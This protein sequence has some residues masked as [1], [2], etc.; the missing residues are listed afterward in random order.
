LMYQ[1]VKEMENDIIKSQPKYVNMQMKYQILSAMFILRFDPIEK[2]ATQAAQIWKS[3]VDAPVHILRMIIETLIK[4]VFDNIQAKHEELQDMGLSCMRGLV[5]KFGERIV[6]ESLD[7]FEGYL[8]EATDLTQTS[9][10]NRVILNMAGAASHRLLLQIK[11]RLTSFADPF[12][13]SEDDEIRELAT[14]VFLTLFKRLGD[15]AYI[16]NILDVSFLQ[17]V[18]ILMQDKSNTKSKVEIEA[19]IKSVTFMLDQAPD[20]RLEEKIMHLCGVPTHSLKTP[21]SI[22]Q[23]RMLRAIAPKVAPFVFT[24]KFYNTLFTALSDE[25]TNDPLDI[26]DYDKER[27]QALLMCFA[28]LAACIPDHEYVAINDEIMSFHD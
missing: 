10:I 13:V 21:L 4:M 26:A 8:E 22:A 3:L 23:A 18:H 20:L 15:A 14:R 25:L 16:Q 17:K 1:L 28:E 6:N 2:V 7:I 19:L 5:E 11:Q 24:K 27:M 12:L 9:G